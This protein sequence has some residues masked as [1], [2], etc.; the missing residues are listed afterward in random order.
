[1]SFY[2]INEIEVWDAE[3]Y[4]KYQ[5]INTALV[6]KLGGRYVVRGGAV[7]PC[8]GEAPQRVVVI[9]FDTLDDMN[10]WKNAPEYAEAKIFRDQSSKHRS[11][12]VEAHGSDWS[13]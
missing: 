9:E 3:T 11:Y 4:A 13:R 7:T 6:L 2:A 5:A 8:E 10:A 1:M 12:Y